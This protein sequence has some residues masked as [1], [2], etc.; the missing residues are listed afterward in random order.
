MVLEQRPRQL[1]EFGGEETMSD[2]Q[3]IVRLPLEDLRVLKITDMA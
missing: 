2:G 3:K 1:C